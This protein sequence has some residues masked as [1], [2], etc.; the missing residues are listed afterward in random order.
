MIAIRSLFKESQWAYNIANLI[1]KSKKTNGRDQHSM[2]D[3]MGH[4]QMHV[5]NEIHERRITS[6]AYQPNLLL[7]LINE[8]YGVQGGK[9]VIL[10]L[11]LQQHKPG[12]I[13]KLLP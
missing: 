4:T 10:R 13:T 7:D 11:C 12:I 6:N 1:L 3:L 5:D 2:L 8:V 9:M